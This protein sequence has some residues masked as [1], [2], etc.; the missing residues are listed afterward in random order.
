MAHSKTVRDAVRAAY[1]NESLPLQ[2]IA[3]LHGVSQP[4]IRQW[5][6]RAKKHGD[7]WERARLASEVGARGVTEAS[8]AMLVRYLRQAQMLMPKIEDDPQIGTADKI[9]L[10]AMLSDSYSKM[11]AS[12][13]RANPRINELTLAMDVVR[14]LADFVVREHAG[15]APALVAVLEAFGPT[16][17][18]K[19]G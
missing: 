10:M 17:T 7:D 1:V 8:E 14:M 16:L 18:S 9:K 12:F 11:T 19:Y 4:V 3:D 15:H 5:K 13:A 2:R 6:A